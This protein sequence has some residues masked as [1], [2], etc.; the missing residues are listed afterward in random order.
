[1]FR[2]AFLST[3]IVLSALAGLVSVFAGFADGRRGALW[4]VVQ[5]C[6]VNHTI[7]GFAFPCLEVNTADGEDRGYVVLRQPGTRDIVLAPTKQVVGVEDP[8]LRTAEAPNYFKDAWDA[9]SFLSELER[10][11]VGHQEVALAVN[12]RTPARARSTPYPHRMYLA[13]LKTG[14]RLGRTG[15]LGQRM[16]APQLARSWP[17]RLGAAN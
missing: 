16:D 7:T 12:S 8:W 13:R 1:M 11:P 6:V 5:T 17:R 4:E 3:T 2:I 15:T 9:R 14:D 10:R